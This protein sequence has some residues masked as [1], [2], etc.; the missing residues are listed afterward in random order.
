MSC[1]LC[2]TGLILI[3]IPLSNVLGYDFTSLGFR[4]FSAFLQIMLPSLYLTL[5]EARHSIFLLFDIFNLCHSTHS[6][7]SRF[8]IS[9]LTWT[10]WQ[11]LS[12][13]S[14]QGCLTDEGF[15]LLLRKWSCFRFKCF[16]M[17]IDS[18]SNL[19]FL[20]SK[21]T[22]YDELSLALIEE[23]YAIWIKDSLKYN[24]FTRWYL[25]CCLQRLFSM[26]FSTLTLIHCSLDVERI[27]IARTLCG[28]R[29][30]NRCQARYLARHAK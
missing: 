25:T 16:T 9:L 15:S 11:R 5:G 17:Y 8:G 20:L 28:Q 7:F 22:T 13:L 18:Q 29:R 2:M 19:H 1:Q 10:L 21:M 3:R 26:I 4:P 24:N 14:S 27:N 23:L 30:I 6:W 12:G